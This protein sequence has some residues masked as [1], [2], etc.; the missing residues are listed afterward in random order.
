MALWQLIVIACSI[1]SV[2]CKSETERV[3]FKIIAVLLMLVA[4]I[5]WLPARVAH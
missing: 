5:G 2:N 4:M 3:A 1:L